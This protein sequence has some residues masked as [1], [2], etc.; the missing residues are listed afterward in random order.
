LL[1][2]EVWMVEARACEL[3]EVEVIVED[4]GISHL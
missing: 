4:L 1:V 2:F 3:S